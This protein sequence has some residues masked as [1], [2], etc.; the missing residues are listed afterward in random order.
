[1]LPKGLWICISKDL[2]KTTLDVLFN[3]FCACD[4]KYVA[5]PLLKFFS[6]IKTTPVDSLLNQILNFPL[7]LPIREP[8]TFLVRGIWGNVLTHTFLDV[9]SAL[10]AA[11]FKKSF[12]LNIFLLFINKGL[13]KTRPTWP[14][15]KESCNRTLRLKRLRLCFSLNLNFL[16][17]STNYTIYYKMGYN[18]SH[19]K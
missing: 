7:P 6:S 16:G 4:R 13:V 15:D 17:W 12:N 19:E 1:M 14:K 5:L 8:I 10:R 18:K 9:L 3:L 11:F 2:Q